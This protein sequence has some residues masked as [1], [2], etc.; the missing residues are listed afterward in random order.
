[1]SKN[2]REKFE[3]ERGRCEDIEDDDVREAVLAYGD[4]MDREYDYE[5][6]P[7]PTSTGAVTRESK[8][9]GTAAIYLSAV[10]SAH[11]RGLNLLEADAETVNHFML[12]LVNDPDDR[13]YGLVDEDYE[14]KIQKSSGQRWQ[15][16]LIGFYR[17]CTEPGVSDDRPTVAVEW[18]A[19]DIHIFPDRS[20]PKYDEDDMPEQADLDAL[21]EACL[22]SQNTHRDRAL[23]ELAAG[24]GQRVY[25]LVTLKVKHVR[26]EDEVPHILLNP[27]IDGDGDKNAIEYTGRFKPIVSDIGPIREWLRHHPLRDDDVRARYDGVPEQFEDCYL[28]IGALNHKDTDPTSHWDADAARD[29]LVRRKENTKTMPGVKTVDVPVNPHNWRHY[30]YTR[31]KD[32]AIPESKRR[33]VFGWARDSNIGERLYDHKANTDNSRDFA[34]A[35]AETFGTEGGTSVAEQVVGDAALADLSPEATRAL[36]RELAT[37]ETAMRELAAAVREAAE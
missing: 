14:D 34:D 22:Y 13:R 8:S 3:R 23:L 32:L 16:A 5:N 19:D 17:Y 33:S 20:D 6:A 27:E 37:D 9:N 28:L 25:A 7:K 26:L 2:P 36:V 10:R 1:M 21:R 29:M 12:D 11:D 24:T 30:A 35:W 4:A 15:S 18:P 31:S